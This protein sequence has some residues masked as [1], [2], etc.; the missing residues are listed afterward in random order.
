LRYIAALPPPEVKLTQTSLTRNSI[1]RLAADAFNL[2]IG[3]IT[4][5]LTARWLGA[6]GK[7]VL[8]SISYLAGLGVNLGLLGLGEAQI[9]LVGQ[10]R[11]TAER[12]F[13]VTTTACLLLGA[14]SGVVLWAIGYFQ[15]H[16]DW[17]LAA[18]PLALTA[19]VVPAS[20]LSQVATHILNAR[21]R[22]LASSALLGLS[23]LSLLLG[24]VILVVVLPGGVTGAAGAAALSIVLTTSVA[25]AV[26]SRSG[27]PLKLAWD[28]TYLREAIRLGTRLQLASL[29][30]GLASRFDQLLV[31][32]LSGAAAA[33]QY[34]VALSYGTLSF[35]PPFALA[36]ATFPRLSGLASAEASE[37]TARGARLA[38][39]LTLIVAIPMALGAPFAIRLA[40]GPVFE[41]ATA[42]AIILS[43]GS[44]FLAA[45][46]FL[47]R[48]RAARGETRL[49]VES[50]ALTAV[51]MAAL[52]LFLIPRFGL[53]GAAAASVTGNAAGLWWCLRAGGW[54][55]RAATLLLPR[56][57]ELANA[58]ASLRR[59]ARR[60][61]ASPDA[62]AR[63]GDPPADD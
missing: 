20:M 63:A 36:Y 34:S 26:V 30:V 37:L 23:A 27:I 24:T 17:H 35:L 40:F 48:G 46:F 59:A 33:G 56:F 18:M 3:L 8:S 47:A 19:L 32:G 62:N 25:L 1:A 60:N 38:V 57:H 61:A 51:V 9:V 54:P 14:A 49:M 11:V 50:F 53:I 16:R 4:A 45:Q 22:I 39:I 42:P 28:G 10:K 5:I 15:F 13:S 58:V 55:E 31:Y 2:A 52:D 7:G 41:P 29:F 44:V 43:L 6:E 12:A 21:E